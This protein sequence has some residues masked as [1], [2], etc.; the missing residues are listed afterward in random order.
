MI[1]D[2][3]EELKEYDIYVQVID[4]VADVEKVRAEYEIQ[5]GRLEDK[6]SVDTVIFVVSHRE[7]ME[8]SFLEI[9]GLYRGW[10]NHF[11]SEARKEAAAAIGS[12]W[13]DG[14]KVLI[15]VNSN[16]DRREAWEL[17]YLYWRR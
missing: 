15:D 13:E 8:M 5:Q 1:V 3:V 14:E 16:F 11:L 2:I 17:G 7:F 9:K 6:C 12:N 4:P 10:S